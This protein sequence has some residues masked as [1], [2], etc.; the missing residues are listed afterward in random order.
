MKPGKNLSIVIPLL[1]EEES[2]AELCE[3][4]VGVCKER[5]FTFEIIF[6]DDG[7]TDSSWKVIS[8]LASQFPEV[9][10]IR[11]SKNFGKSAALDCGF[12]AALGEVVITLD[13]DLQDSPDEIPAL[14]DMIRNENF[15]MVSGWKKKRHDPLSKTI[16]SKF[17][18]GVTALFSGIKLHDFNCGLKAYDYKLVRSL[19]L[20]G[21][22]HRYI[23]LL[24]KWNGFTRIGEKIVEHRPRKFGKTK[25]GIE[26]FM[27]GFLDLLSV[28]FVTRFANRPMH[29]FGTLGTLSFL[30]GLG[31][32][33]KIIWEKISAIYQHLPVKREVVDQPIFFIALAAI[34][35]GVQL[36][37][38]GF[39][40][41]LIIRQQ[42]SKG[43]SVISEKIGME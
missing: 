32:V 34:I 25:F 21:E 26:R 10:G 24:A 27:Y 33:I 22:M 4:I 17:F 28:T 12:R 23:P 41:E 42:K 30:V 36:F 38:A 29:L 43:D 16:P 40:G 11:L 5:S 1:N 15:D 39:L 37:L 6:V 7:S 8:S 31:L 9:K 13:A 14:A 19:H 2:L 35:I 20:Y 18:N 3:R